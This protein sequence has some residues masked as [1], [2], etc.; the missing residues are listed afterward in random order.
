MQL[1]EHQAQKY[2]QVRNAFRNHRIVCSQDPTGSGKT[3]L[4]SAMTKAATEKGRKTW[5]IVP[6][7]ELLEQTS[8][9]LLKF[10]VDHGF[11]HA[12]KKEDKTKSVHVVS[13]DTLIRHLGEHELEP[14]FIIVD[15]CHIAL[16]RY[17]K[18]FEYYKRA[19]GLGLTATPEL[20]G[21][22]RGLNELY[23]I[24]IPGPTL[25]ELVEKNY[26]CNMQYFC[27]PLD[28]LK[29]IKNHGTEFDIESLREFF[30]ANGVYGS[31][32][33]HWLE[34]AYGKST[35][36]FCRSVEDCKIIAEKFCET[37]F[38]FEP[39]DGNMSKAERKRIIN[40]LTEGRI[41]G[42][43]SCDL[44]TYGLDVPRVDCIVM[45]RPTLSRALFFQMIGRGARTFPGKEI[46]VVLDHVN[47]IFNNL[48][49]HK[50]EHPLTFNDWNFDGKKRKLRKLNDD[51][52]T[53]R[54]CP[55]LGEFGFEYCSKPSC[56]GCDLNKSGV[57]HRKRQ[58]SKEI[59]GKL[60]EVCYA[61]FCQEKKDEINSSINEIIYKW[62]EGLGIG[63]RDNTLVK[64]MLIIA[65]E[66]KYKPLWVYNKMNMDSGKVDKELLHVIGSMKKYSLG[67]A[68]K[69]IE[70]LKNV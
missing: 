35:I 54:L 32:T 11:I 58:T 62:Q 3:V 64:K 8:E 9:K 41:T 60:K 33:Q 66:C 25:G 65:E 38:H 20:M 48:D 5:I 55:E 61:D 53:A 26:L 51:E 69:Q 67:W 63:R 18:I 22:K 4:L 23:E 6:R 15:E 14:D 31:A 1:Y 49:F 2:N 52:I 36:V 10:N 56:S 28:G 29:N 16:D 17:I 37:G 34:R 40:D 12:E 59:D 44:V 70:R 47:N 24:L 19:F 13:S 27:P 50:K 43:T 42:I 30:A 39:I 7:I 45:L 46:F 57:D 21:G 68:N